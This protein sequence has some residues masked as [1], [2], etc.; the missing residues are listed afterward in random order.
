MVSVN[1]STMAVTNGAGPS[2]GVPWTAA[3]DAAAGHDGSAWGLGV[4]ASG[5]ILQS[6]AKSPVTQQYRPLSRFSATQVTEPA[7]MV[8]VV[9]PEPNGILALA[10][11]SLL[12]AKRR[13]R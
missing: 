11:A 10:T 5:T 4:T 2:S 1:T 7:A 9:A 12:I 6:Y 3:V 8:V 13:K